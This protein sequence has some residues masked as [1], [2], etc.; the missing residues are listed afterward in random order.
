MRGALGAEIGTT[1]QP[2]GSEIKEQSTT[3]VKGENHPPGP[4]EPRCPCPLFNTLAN[5][6]YI[7]RNGRNVLV[8]DLYAGVKLI[9]FTP[10]VAAS[11]TYPIYNEMT[12]T[13]T[14]DRNDLA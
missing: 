9:G 13:N 7:P 11:L 2:D 6:G 1:A 5:H 4:K 14:E 8:E 12:A 10:T 3:L